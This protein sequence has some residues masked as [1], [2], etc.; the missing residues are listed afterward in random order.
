MTFKQDCEDCGDLIKKLGL[1]A[2]EERWGRGGSDLGLCLQFLYCMQ[3]LPCSTTVWWRLLRY[4]GRVLFLSDLVHLTLRL[5]TRLHLSGLG[6]LELLSRI[7]RPLHPLLH[8]PLV[9]DSLQPIG[10]RGRQCKLR[11]HMVSTLHPHPLHLPYPL[12][13]AASEMF[14]ET[15]I[16]LHGNTM[17]HQRHPAGSPKRYRQSSAQFHRV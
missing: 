13:P 14:G 3:F 6:I 12:P 7:P 1:L 2:R 16:N 5:S 8:L 17:Q 11:Y 4:G 9:R 15:Y 10:L